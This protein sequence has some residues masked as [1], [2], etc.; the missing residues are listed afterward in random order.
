MKRQVLEPMNKGKKKKGLACQDQRTKES[1]VER[2]GPEIPGTCNVAKVG[3]R[4]M[5][6]EPKS[7]RNEGHICP[8]QTHSDAAKNQMA[9]RATSHE[10]KAGTSGHPE[11][12]TIRESSWENLRLGREGFGSLRKNDKNERKPKS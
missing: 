7:T 3:L 10:Q 1:P 4:Q 9:W 6:R 12:R 8:S 2:T 11:R 5:R